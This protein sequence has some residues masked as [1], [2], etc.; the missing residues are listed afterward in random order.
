[1]GLRIPIFKNNSL[2]LKRYTSDLK[3]DQKY[4]ETVDQ[5]LCTL[6]LN[7]GIPVGELY[8]GLFFARGLSAKGILFIK[9]GMGKS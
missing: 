6:S 8:N 3:R 9:S 1:M 5:V 2:D 7:L 4:K